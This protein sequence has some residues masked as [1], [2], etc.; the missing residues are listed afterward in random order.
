MYC[1]SWVLVQPVSNQVY[2]VY[3]LS[4]QNLS[5]TMLAS[6]AACL[7]SFLFGATVP[8]GSWFAIATSWGATGAMSA[9]LAAVA[10]P[11]GAVAAGVGWYYLRR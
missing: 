2:H 9:P 1:H 4:V 10:G 7:Q 11:V 8:A 5:N 6:I 3:T